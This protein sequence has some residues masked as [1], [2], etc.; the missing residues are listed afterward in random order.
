MGEPIRVVTHVRRHVDDGH[1]RPHEA[2][3]ESPDRT[4]SGLRT[5]RDAD[6]TSAR[7]A[8]SGSRRGDRDDERHGLHPHPR[9][10][11]Q[12]PEP[13]AARRCLSKRAPPGSRRPGRA[14]R[15][16]E[17]PAT[18]PES[19]C[20]VGVD[21]ERV[22]ETERGGDA[23]AGRQGG[24]APTIVGM[25]LDPDPGALRRD[26]SRRRACRLAAAVVHDET[27]QPSDVEPRHDLPIVSCG[28]RS[29]S[30]GRASC[31]IAVRR[32]DAAAAGRE[33]GG[34]APQPEL[35]RVLRLA[36]ARRATGRLVPAGGRL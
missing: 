31:G 7:A 21:L 8:C 35:D 27:G 4:P 10:R 9:A 1:A 19:C 5:G 29:G 34:A 32:A 23:I 2:N 18:S 15:R 24:A 12:R 22:R 28:C 33:H 3:D 13:A 20:R 11:P 25:A 30:A 17:R 6:A 16:R 14:A 36:R 26:A